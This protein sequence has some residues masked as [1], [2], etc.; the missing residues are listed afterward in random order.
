MDRR[1]FLTQ[2]LSV[3]VGGVV[4]QALDG[5]PCGGRS[6]QGGGEE[7]EEAE[8][9]AWAFDYLVAVKM[10]SLSTVIVQRLE[11]GASSLNEAAAVTVGT[12]SPPRITSL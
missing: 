3:A 7:D 1:R 10:P 11:S 8:F 6:S 4:A 12:P 9:H 2:A 5:L